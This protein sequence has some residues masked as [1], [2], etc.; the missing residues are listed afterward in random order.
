MPINVRR[1]A[2][3]TLNITCNFLCIVIIRCTEMF[4]SPCI[5]FH[6]IH[7]EFFLM[8]L[9][10]ITHASSLYECVGAIRTKWAKNKPIGFI[11]PVRLTTCNS[12]RIT[13]L[14][15]IKFRIGK[16]YWNFNKIFDG[17]LVSRHTVKV[18][19]IPATGRGGPRGS[20]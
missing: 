9:Y 6:L 12:W 3:D 18:K 11:M 16:R 8:K 19:V 7:K 1:L 14:F 4:W 2:G 13:E 5:S 20:G 17:Q 10:A 15:C